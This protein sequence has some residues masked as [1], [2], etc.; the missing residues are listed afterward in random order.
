MKALKRLTKRLTVRRETV[1][2][3]VLISSLLCFSLAYAATFDGTGQWDVNATGCNNTCGRPE[4]TRGQFNVYLI[5]NGDAVTI[6]NLDDP[7][8]SSITGTVSGATYTLSYTWSD[9]S[10]Y[11]KLWVDINETIVVTASS[12]TQASGPDDWT[13]PAYTCGGSCNLSLSRRTQNPAIFDATGTWQ[14]TTSNASTSCTETTRPPVS[15]MLSITQTGTKVTATTLVNGQ[16][17]DYRGFLSGSTYTL[18]RSYLDTGGTVSQ[19]IT[20]DLS[21]GGTGSGSCDWVWTNGVF[22]QDCGGLFDISMTRA[23][24]AVTASA[25]SGGSISPSGSVSVPYNGNQLFTITPNKGYRIQD[26]RVDGVSV[27]AVKSYTLS[28]V[29]VAH[30]IEAVFGKNAGQSFLQLLLDD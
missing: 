10:T 19:V 23:A 13:A 16:Q 24:L 7:S 25:G 22:G 30:T 17:V 11:Y 5:Q 29:Q 18:I 9:W 14:Y 28:N 12:A 15:G 20:V 26:V 21:N 8:T 6:V 1:F 2:Q 27:G 4:P 3:L